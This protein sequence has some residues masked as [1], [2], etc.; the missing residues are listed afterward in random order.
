MVLLMSLLRLLK[1]VRRGA[2]HDLFWPSETQLSVGG[3]REAIAKMGILPK[4][5]S[6]LGDSSLDVQKN[7]VEGIVNLAQHSESLMIERP[8]L[9]ISEPFKK[10]ISTPETMRKIISLLES[11]HSNPLL[12]EC[13]VGAVGYFAES[14]MLR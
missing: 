13:V 9:R 6:S 4:V 5:L 11:P 14:G 3:V 7:T 12:R 8:H 1:T 2:A 10:S